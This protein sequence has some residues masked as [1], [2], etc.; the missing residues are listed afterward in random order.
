MSP[1]QIPRPPEQERNDEAGDSLSAAS[2]VLRR[3]PRRPYHTPRLTA[4]GRLTEITRF[5]GSQVIDSGGG[6]GQP[7]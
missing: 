7:F 1:P 2:G 5:G 3:R 6:L 4:Y